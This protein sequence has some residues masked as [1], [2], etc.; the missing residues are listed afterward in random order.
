MCDMI[1]GGIAKKKPSLLSS[2]L[3]CVACFCGEKALIKIN[4]SCR[5]FLHYRSTAVFFF[6]PSEHNYYL[7]VVCTPVEM[8]TPENDPLLLVN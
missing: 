8:L 6:L 7:Q 5:G 2:W 4:V 1:W 3:K